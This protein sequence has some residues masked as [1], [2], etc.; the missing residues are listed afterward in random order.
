LAVSKVALSEGD[1]VVAAVRDPSTVTELATSA[2]T[3]KYLAL[4]IDVTSTSS[5]KSVFSAAIEKF[6]R[7]DIVLNSAGYGIVGEVE[8]TPDEA[9]KKLFDVN[10]WGTVNVSKEAIRV[11]RDVNPKGEG[12]RLLNVSSGQGLSSAPAAAFYAASKHAVE[13]FTEGLRKEMDPEWN[14]KVSVLA[15]GAFK[16]NTHV[17]NNQV[18]PAVS[19]YEKPSLPSQFVRKMFKELGFVKGDVEKAAKV[20]YKFS[21][22]EAPPFR[23]AVGKDAVGGVRAKVKSLTEETDEFESWSEDLVLDSTKQ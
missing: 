15:P 4:N 17:L 3:D 23:W 14:I 5:V 21:K 9:A 13:G 16:T 20:I 10:F 8:S 22:L 7:C 1:I 6:G 18:V 2:E 11:F 19:P 12:G